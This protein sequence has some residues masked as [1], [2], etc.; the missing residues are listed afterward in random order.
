MKITKHGLYRYIQRTGKRNLIGTEPILKELINNSIPITRE[1]AI[2]MGYKL[3]NEKRGTSY[4][5]AYEKDIR[6]Y[7]LLVIREDKLIT[8]LNKQMFKFYNKKCKI[9]N[10]VEYKLKE[11][12]DEAQNK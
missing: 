10:D 12:Y 6:E 2:K 8:V 7:I 1:Q 11:G 5:V 3:F 4:R 9:S